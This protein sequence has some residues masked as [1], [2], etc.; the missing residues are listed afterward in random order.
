MLLSTMLYCLSAEMLS[1]PPA[2]EG[3]Q[4]SKHSDM[5]Q[6]DAWTEGHDT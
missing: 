4:S 2:S 6:K 1:H 5:M 3:W